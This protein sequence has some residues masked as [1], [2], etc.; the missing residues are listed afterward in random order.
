[1]RFA[2]AA[3]FAALVFVP[4]ASALPP[5]FTVGDVTDHTL[6]ITISDS[7]IVPHAPCGHTYQVGL[8]VQNK[9]GGYT[10]ATW[11]TFTT[12]PCATPPPPPPPPPPAPPPPPPPPPPSGRVLL[13][14]D[15]G[16]NPTPPSQLPWSE[17]TQLILFNLFPNNDGSLNQENLWNVPSIP[18]WVQTVHQH[19]GI[20][21]IIAIGGAGANGFSGGACNDT[22]RA[23]FVSNFIGFATS[24]GFDGVDLDIEDGGYFAQGPPSPA[25]TTCVN[26]IADAAHAANLYVSADVDPTNNGGMWWAPSQDRISQFNMMTFGDSVTAQ[27]TH[28]QAA[29]SQGLTD[30]G[31]FV[32]GIDIIEHSPPAGGCGPYATDAQAQGLLGMFV[33][34]HAGDTY[35]VANACMDQLFTAWPG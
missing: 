2:L 12:A 8:K 10:G 6:T 26:A 4:A 11:A 31:K 25:M 28:M 15:I 17:I 20:K 35:Q 24:N 1:M 9:S 27:H 5:S 22:H 3:I 13:A 34:A 18:G 21:A 14:E 16:W 29:V 32:P 19:P 7:G 23:Q 30:M 33:W